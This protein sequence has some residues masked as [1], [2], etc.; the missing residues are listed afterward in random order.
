MQRVPGFSSLLVILLSPPLSHLALSFLS[1]QFSHLSRLPFIPLYLYY[2]LLSYISNRYSLFTPSVPF[3]PS[4]CPYH[5]S[6]HILFSFFPP[7]IQTFPSI[8][9]IL[10]ILS[11]STHPFLLLRQPSPPHTHIHIHTHLKPH[12]LL[13]SHSLLSLFSILLGFLFS[14]KP[15]TAS[16]TPP[17][18][19]PSS[20]KALTLLPNS[21]GG[22]RTEREATEKEQRWI[23]RKKGKEG[24]KEGWWVGW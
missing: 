8:I 9:I 21:C 6:I 17:T 4:S 1:F 15:F 23:E 11:A 19:S 24:K 7:F 12:S 2:L 22:V 18:S 20:C 16:H 5:P 14:L 10:E 13:S 3:F